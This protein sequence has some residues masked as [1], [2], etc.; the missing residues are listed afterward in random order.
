MP[1]FQLRHF[2]REDRHIG[3]LRTGAGRGRDGDQRRPLARHLVDAEQIRQGA[4]V[5]GIGRDT[6]G[7]VDSAAAAHPDQA[8]MPAFAVRTHAVF[9][10]GDF[11]VGQHTIKNLVGALAQMLKRQRHGAGLDQRGVRHDQWVIHIQTRELGGQLLDG[12]GAGQ[13]FVGDLE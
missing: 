8:V 6:F 10:D 1:F 11:R 9:D 2:V 7:N 13:Q 3:H 4:V 12:T 5:T